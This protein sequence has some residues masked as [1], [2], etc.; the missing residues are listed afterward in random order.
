MLDFGN[1]PLHP[2]ALLGEGRRNSA[3]SVS[4][5]FPHCFPGPKMLFLL[6]FPAQL[7]SQARL[8]PVVSSHHF[9]ALPVLAHLPKNEHGSRGSSLGKGKK[10]FRGFGGFPHTGKPPNVPFQAPRNPYLPHFPGQQ[11]EGEDLTGWTDAVT[12]SLCMG[13]VAPIR[14]QIKASQTP[15]PQQRGSQRTG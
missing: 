3:I 9:A 4:I 6:T 2:T 8:I 10:P 5:S 1:C 13:L 11:A 7:D 12:A 14:G 15:A